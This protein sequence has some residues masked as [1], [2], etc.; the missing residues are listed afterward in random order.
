MMTR[1]TSRTAE[2]LYANYA[3]SPAQQRKY[4]REHGG[5]WREDDGTTPSPR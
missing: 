4:A 2:D 5:S 1:K 3:D